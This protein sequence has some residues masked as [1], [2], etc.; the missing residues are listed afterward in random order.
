MNTETLNLVDENTSETLTE[1]LESKLSNPATASDFDLY[2]GVN[3]VLKDVGMSAADS[4]GQLTFYGQDPVVPSTFRF[5][6]S[7]AIGLAAKTVAAAAIW[8]DRSGEGQDVHVDLRKAFRRFCGFYEGV[9]ET[10]N[11]RGP[12]MGF[13]EG[14]QFFPFPTSTES[15]NGHAVMPQNSF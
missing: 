8:K 4:G 12:S 14:T 15:A 11:G 1:A 5:G 10:V 13:S 6:T 3:D 9:W 7:A 2:G